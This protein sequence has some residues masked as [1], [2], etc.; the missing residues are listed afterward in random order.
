MSLFLPHGLC[1]IPSEPVNSAWHAV[2]FRL[3]PAL[4]ALTAISLHRFGE[5]AAVV[6]I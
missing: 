2:R 5:S 6:R 4:L 1:E 3:R